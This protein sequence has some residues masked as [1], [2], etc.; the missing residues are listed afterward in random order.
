MQLVDAADDD[1]RGL[2]PVAKR[3]VGAHQL[4]LRRLVGQEHHHV[5]LRPAPLPARL[6][7]CRQ[8]RGAIILVASA[9]AN[10]GSWCGRNWRRPRPRRRCPRPARSPAG[11]STPCNRSRAHCRRA[12]HD[13]V[14]PQPL[15]GL[16]VGGGVLQGIVAR[17]F[18]AEGFERVVEHDFIHRAGADRDFPAPASTCRRSRLFPSTAREGRRQCRRGPENS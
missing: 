9:R 8:H 13:R 2:G 17:V 11:I 7:A 15:A 18:E 12:E 6:A 3:R 16:L 1:V 5:D 10:A 14:G 4:F